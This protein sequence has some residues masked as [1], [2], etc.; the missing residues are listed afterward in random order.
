MWSADVLDDEVAVVISSV[1]DVFD[2]PEL[3]SA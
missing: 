1:T 3:L 2:K